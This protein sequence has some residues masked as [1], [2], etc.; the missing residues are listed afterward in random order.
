VFSSKTSNAKATISGKVSRRKVT[1]TVSER[2]FIPREHHFCTGSAN[3][4][5]TAQ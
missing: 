2:R 3:F 5:L 4:S 1:G